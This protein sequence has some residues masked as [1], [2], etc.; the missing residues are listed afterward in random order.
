[1]R[2]TDVTRTVDGNGRMWVKT[3]TAPGYPDMSACCTSREVQSPATAMVP[4]SEL[5]GLAA[6]L[7]SAAR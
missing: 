7:R 3:E 2:I 1:M 6:L 5:A 4:D